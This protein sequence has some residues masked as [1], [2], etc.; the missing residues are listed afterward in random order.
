MTSNRSNFVSIRGIDDNNARVYGWDGFFLW[1]HVFLPW[2]PDQPVMDPWI[3]LSAIATQTND[4]IIGTTV[5]PLARRRPMVIARETS[6]LDR[7]S[8]GRFIL[9]VGLGGTAELKA[10]GEQKDEKVRELLKQGKTIGCFYVESPA[11]RMLLTKLEAT[12]ANAFGS[13]IV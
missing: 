7:L 13:H 10:L 5:T 2:S 11:M 1:D 9:G 4:I 3:V 8:N 12:G 6:T